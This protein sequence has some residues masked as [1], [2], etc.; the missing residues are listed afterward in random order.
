MLCIA[1][2]SELLGIIINL[3]K[4]VASIITKRAAYLRVK[5]RNLRGG[6][7]HDEFFSRSWTITLSQ[8]DFR[9]EVDVVKENEILK[10]E[11]KAL[12]Q[13][14]QASGDTIRRIQE[15]V[16]GRGK[17]KS[18]ERSYSDRHL[19]H[20]KK[21]RASSSLASLAWLEQEGLKPLVLEVY[22]VNSGLKEKIELGSIESVLGVE[23]GSVDDEQRDV[24]SMMVYVKD[25]YSVSGS[26]YHEMAKFC[27]EMPRYY[28]LQGRIKAL[29]SFWN[30]KPTPNGVSGV[31]TA[32]V[33]RPTFSTINSL[34]SIYPS[35]CLL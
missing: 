18:S 13:Q 6:R 14:L 25:R 11:I 4:S 3:T 31:R 34:N 5:S 24:I 7:Q 20:L 1:K 12:R 2:L 17:R 21:H 9:R 23:E 33:E 16:S 8:G 22:N 27:R 28:K 32:V 35:K 10:G 30:I 26:A 15:G 29:N 19:W